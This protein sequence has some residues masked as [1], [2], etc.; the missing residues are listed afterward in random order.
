MISCRFY[1]LVRDDRENVSVE[2]MRV[3]N[4]TECLQCGAEVKEALGQVEVVR[5]KRGAGVN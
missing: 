4:Q 1:H 2:K 3:C 5:D